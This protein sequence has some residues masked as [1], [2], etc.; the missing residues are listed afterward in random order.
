MA[1]GTLTPCFLLSGH[2]TISG[3]G[4]VSERYVLV[5]LN[6][7]TSCAHAKFNAVLTVRGKGTLDA[8]A[9]TTRCTTIGADLVPFRFR[10]VGGT[11]PFSGATGSGTLTQ[12]NST[13]TGPDRGTE[14]DT[15]VGRLGLAG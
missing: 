14:T 6:S 11:G 2:G 5:V 8:I 12:S 10:V 9:A 3:I 1:G 7:G 4:S 13:D 15:W